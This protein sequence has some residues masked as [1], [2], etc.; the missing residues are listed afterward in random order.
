MIYCICKKLQRCFYKQI[1]YR[2]H[3]C[4][5]VAVLFVM[6]R[7]KNMKFYMNKDKSIMC[8]Y[9]RKFLTKADKRDPHIHKLVC[10]HCG[11]WI[12]FIPKH[13]YFEVKKKPER[14]CSSGMRFY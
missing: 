13:N 11:K 4:L 10:K 8:P 14:K 5:I 9:C 7:G 3:R 2:K 1:P 12:H 6:Q